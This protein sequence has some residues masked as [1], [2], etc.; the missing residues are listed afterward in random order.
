MVCFTTNVGK[1]EHCIYSADW[2]GTRKTGAVLSTAPEFS[3]TLGLLRRLLGGHVLGDLVL[4]GVLGGLVLRGVLG[5]L[6]LRDV[7]GRLVGGGLMRGRLYGG[8]VRGGCWGGGERAGDRCDEE[9]GGN[10]E[11]GKNALHEYTPLTK[12]GLS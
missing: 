6:V 4:A 5:G 3:V 12:T 10:G 2:C 9:S 11:R 8:G 1:S 7:L